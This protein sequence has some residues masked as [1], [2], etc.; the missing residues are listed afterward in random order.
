MTEPDWQAVAGLNLTL[1]SIP[2]LALR[3]RTDPGAPATAHRD[4]LDQTNPN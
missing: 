1:P 3:N 4:W 2:R